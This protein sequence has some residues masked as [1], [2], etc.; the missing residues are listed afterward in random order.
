MRVEQVEVPRH[1]RERVVLVLR[2]D[3]DQLL[4]DALEHALRRQ[5]GLHDRAPAPRASDH[6][7]EHQ[8]LALAGRHV[9][10]VEDRRDAPAGRGVE[11]E[12]ALDA[13]RLCAL[14]DQ[15]GAAPGAA[16]QRQRVDDDRLA[17]AGLAGQHVHAAPELER[18]VVE[19][20]QSADVQ[21]AEHGPRCSTVARR[22]SRRRARD[23]V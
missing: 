9:E 1:V 10:L 4:A 16:Q 19:E 12:L 14:T 11:L 3:V 23:L 5:V 2:A 6:A 22:R 13:R 15:V 7:L 20:G 17:R 21:V 8:R 18:D